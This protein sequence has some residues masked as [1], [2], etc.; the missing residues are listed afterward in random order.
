MAMAWGAYL[1]ARQDGYYPE[2]AGRRAGIAAETQ[3]AWE[4]HYTLLQQAQAA[5]ERARTV[6]GD[7]EAY[8]L[9]DLSPQAM[10]AL[11][12]FAYFRVRYFGRHATPWQEEAAHTLVALLATPAKGVVVVNCPP[13]SSKD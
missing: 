9:A 12:D 6:A 4:K 2:D 1:Q 10:R 3:A 7:V 13:G 8:A 11:N 5:A